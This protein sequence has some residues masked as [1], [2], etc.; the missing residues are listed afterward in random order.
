MKVLCILL[1]AAGPALGQTF[2]P[3]V[4]DSLHFRPLFLKQC[5][6]V[7][8]QRPD[9]MPCRIL[10]LASAERMPVRQLPNGRPIDRMPVDRG[11][12]DRRAIYWTPIEGRP[13]GKK[14]SVKTP[15]AKV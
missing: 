6:S 5:D 9:N 8:I 4:R 10:N 12:V 13:E 11:P 3:A 14:G 7:R 2:V 15:P 1:L